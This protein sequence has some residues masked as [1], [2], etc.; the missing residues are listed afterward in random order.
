MN[1]LHLQARERRPVDLPDPVLINRQLSGHDS[2]KVLQVLSRS[3]HSAA[4]ARA[5]PRQQRRHGE[6]LEEAHRPVGRGLR[7]QHRQDGVLE[8]CRQEA[9]AK[10]A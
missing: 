1:L 7:Q 5:G 6:A 9:E 4:D 2:R 10:V 8:A 3:L